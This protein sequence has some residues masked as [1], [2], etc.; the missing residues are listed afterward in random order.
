MKSLHVFAAAILFGLP[1]LGA[2]LAAQTNSS[3][4]PIIQFDN[5]AYNFGKVNNG[6]FVTHT[7]FVTNAGDATLEIT[8]VHPACGCTTTAPWTHEIPPGQSGSIPIKFNSSH[9][10]GNVI[11]T[12]DVYSNAKN[13]PHAILHL[14]G[15]IWKPVVLTPQMATIT[16]SLDSSS[17][18]MSSVR[19]LNQ[20]D[21]PL[22]LSDPVPSNKKFA[23]EIKTTRPGKEYQLVI[24]ALPP[25]AVGNTPGTISLK[26]SLSNMATLNVSVFLSVQPAVVVSPSRVSLGPCPDRWTTNYVFIHGNGTNLLSLSEPSCSDSRVTVSIRPI[27]PARSMFNLAIALPPNYQIP[28]SQHVTVTVKTSNPKFPLVTIPLHQFAKARFSSGPPLMPATA[29]P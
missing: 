17:P 13:Q 1:L 21:Q 5:A 3:S 11:K 12:I 16:A 2:P 10:S 6:E 22:T 23:A 8:N 4:G 14:T 20:S 27:Q 9:F 28:P 7:Y 19:I 15:A 18:A 29:H 25:F 24:S 26:T